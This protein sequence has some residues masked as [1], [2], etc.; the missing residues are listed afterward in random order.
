MKK[1]WK[2]YSKKVESHSHRTSE[3]LP[4]KNT[5]R[6]LVKRFGE[7][8]QTNSENFPKK[9]MSENISGEWRRTDPKKIG[10]LGQRSL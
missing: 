3:H 5:M 1:I 7:L 10:Q 2:M 4:E 8:T 9:L 6:M